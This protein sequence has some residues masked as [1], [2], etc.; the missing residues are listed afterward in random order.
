M[1]KFTESELDTGS[2]IHS[3]SSPGGC[4]QKET[5]QAELNLKAKQSDPDKHLFTIELGQAPVGVSVSSLAL[6][7]SIVVAVFYEVSG[8][9]SVRQ[10]RSIQYNI[11]IY[12]YL[13][14]VSSYIVI[15][16]YITSYVIY[17][18]TYICISCISF[19]DPLL[20]SERVKTKTV[21][22]L[23]GSSRTERLDRSYVDPQEIGP[24]S[25]K[26]SVVAHRLVGPYK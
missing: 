9:F 21:G 8:D 4:A 25:P 26:S 24:R 22:S 14:I 6:V 13:F 1:L 19:V 18:L 15:S 5:C 2:S 16:C 10:F 20:C 17:T 11:Y 12:I 23:G 3:L 7:T